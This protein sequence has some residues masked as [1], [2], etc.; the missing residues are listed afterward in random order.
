MATISDPWPKR[1]KP[2]GHPADGMTLEVDVGGGAAMRIVDPRSLED[3]GLEWGLRYGAA[4]D[5]RYTAAS[6]IESYDY[7]LSSAINEAEALRRLRELRRVRA[8]AAGE[9]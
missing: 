9:I 3:G 6:V 1:S 8:V 7:L 2:N 4:G 5:L